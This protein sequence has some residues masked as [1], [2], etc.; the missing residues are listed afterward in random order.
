MT[1]A[2]HTH[3]VNDGDTLAGGNVLAGFSVAVSDVLPPRAA[4]PS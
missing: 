1:L 2:A 3:T 4:A